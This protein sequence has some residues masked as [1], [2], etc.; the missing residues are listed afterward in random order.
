MA[1]T[2]YLTLER[3]HCDAK[4]MDF[5]LSYKPFPGNQLTPIYLLDLT[6]FLSHLDWGWY[7]PWPRY[8]FMRHISRSL[9]DGQL[10]NQ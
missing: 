5:Y 2:M 10:Y 3:R 8:W 9:A 4:R 6:L 7:G 1:N